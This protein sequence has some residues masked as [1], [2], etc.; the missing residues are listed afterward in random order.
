M[1]RGSRIGS[2]LLCAG[3]LTVIVAASLGQ[4]QT[5]ESQAA[6]TPSQAVE[7]LKDGNVRFVSGQTKARDWSAKVIATAK[8]QYPFAAVVSCIDSR[9]PV[10]IVFDQGIGDIFV[11]RTAGNVVDTDV[12]GGLEFATKV[13][14]AKYV[15]VMGHTECGAV[16][17]AID[18]V[19]MG[20]LTALLAKI[21]SAVRDSGPGSS[22]DPAYVTKVTEKNVRDSI[23]EIKAR[24]SILRELIDSGQVGIKGAM[25][26]VATGRVNFLN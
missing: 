18:G 22:K 1:M 2:A 21:Q 13:A 9:A 25:Y 23:D 12:F 11:L 6:M 16:K 8:G 10:E 19:R 24:S 20:N 26:D 3:A 5:K 14:G 15:V 7:N 4:V 17:G